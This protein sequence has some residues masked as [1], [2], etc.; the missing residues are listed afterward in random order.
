MTRVHSLGL[1]DAP[2]SARHT[3][4]MDEGEAGRPLIVAVED[5]PDTR[6]F[7]ELSSH[8]TD[9]TEA[10]HA[11]DWALRATQD[12]AWADLKPYLMGSAVVSYC[13]CF[14]HSNV[15]APLSDRIDI[16]PEMNGI[17]ETI[18]VFRNQTIAH[19]QS[20]LTVTYP[21]GVLDAKT[22][23]LQS[24]SAL[25]VASTLPDSIAEDFARLI[26]TVLELLDD[27][28]DPVRGRLEQVLRTTAPEALVA[29][30]P[31]AIDKF[32]SQF[33]PRSKRG[34]YPT[35]YTFHWDRQ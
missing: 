31:R 33:D 13:R 34:P 15:R 19:S 12:D 5:S 24:V 1:A 3:L 16:P 32:A 8:A 25:T 22:M 11:L 28:L 27:A 7:I 21:V 9:L 17:H 30:P 29:A 20:E 14:L 2:G 4:E 6:L 26:R 10:S 23:E 35:A 18:R